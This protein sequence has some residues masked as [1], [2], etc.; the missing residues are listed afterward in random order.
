[1]PVQKIILVRF[2]HLVMPEYGRQLRLQ[3]TG[4]FL[5]IS[6]VVHSFSPFRSAYSGLDLF[7]S[8]YSGFGQFSSFPCVFSGPGLFI[9]PLFIQAWPSCAV[10]LF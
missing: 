9:F 8:D 2:P 4:M 7:S 5:V 3:Q 6:S 10:F 1:M